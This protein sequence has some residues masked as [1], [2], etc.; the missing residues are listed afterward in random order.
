MASQFL[1]G[2][3]RT[4]EPRCLKKKVQGE[5]R[6]SQP[7]WSTK[8]EINQAIDGEKLRRGCRVGFVAY[9]IEF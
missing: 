1:G 3:K 8:Q 7:N 4:K 2:A 9:N 5:K 6:K